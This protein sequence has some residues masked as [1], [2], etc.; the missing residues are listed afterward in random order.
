[1]DE[2]E[3]PDEMPE[4]EGT[5]PE[6]S[7]DEMR[8]L[9]EMPEPTPGAI[10]HGKVVRVEDD[11]ALVDVGYKSEGV[12]PLGELTYRHVASAR[13]VTHVGDEFDVL[14]LSVGGEDGTLRLSKRRADEAKSWRGL[15]EAYR[16]GTVLEVPVVEAVKG[17]LVADVGTRGFIPASQVDRGYVEDLSQYVGQTVR[18]RI[19][20]LDPH[21]RRVILSRRQ[22]LEEER[23]KKREETWNTIQV[24]DVLEGTVKSLTDFGAFIDLGGVDGLLH[25]SEMSWGRIRHPSEVLQE[26]QRVKVQVLR[27]DRER[28]RI[29]L[30]MRQVLPNPWDTAAERYREG[31]IV[32]GTVVRLAT[33]GA[34][35]ELE[36]G[37]DGLVHISQLADYHVSRPQD[38][39]QVGQRVWVKVLRVDPVE[40]RISLSLKQAE[41]AAPA[42][43]TSAEGAATIGEL[44]DEDL[45]KGLY[46]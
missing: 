36:P 29:S 8:L 34:F 40:R 12:V 35:V 17:G 41:G 27:L 46:S 22:V 42:G 3:R 37:I 9:S 24:G 6:D 43:G 7:A 13:E 45:K 25:I 14:V 10:L 44:L 39:V 1:L 31:A 11:H 23:A 18:V 15:E 19:I 26:G 28:E 2:T 21:K 32:E 4:T 20:E 33:F 16:N 38:V 5:T 30:G